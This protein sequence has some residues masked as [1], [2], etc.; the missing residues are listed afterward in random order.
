MKI[1][2]KYILKCIHEIIE[3]YHENGAKSNKN[4]TNIYLTK[5]SMITPKFLK[6]KMLKPMYRLYLKHNTKTN[7]LE[8]KYSEIDLKWSLNFLEYSLTHEV[9]FN[10]DLFENDN[11]KKEIIKFIKNKLYMALRGQL[12]T[13]NLFTEDD[14]TYFKKYD[15]FFR[16]N[17][18]FKN[19]N[20]TDI[21]YNNKKYTLASSN[22][23]ISS[24]YHNYGLDIIP[25]KVISNIA[26]KNILDCGAFVGDSALIFEKLKPKKIYSFEP[27][28]K[29][30]LKLIE[31]IKLNNLNPLITPIKKGLG[32]KNK[33]VYLENALDSSYIKKNNLKTKDSEKI[34]ITTIDN[35]IQDNV[36]LI[37]MDI[38]GYELEAIKGAEKTIK[39]NRP[40]LLICLYHTGKDFFEIPKLINKWNL[41]YTYRFLNLYKIHPTNERVLIAYPN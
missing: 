15:D 40:V 8:Y 27:D 3:E 19:A 21:N 9:N 33:N 6:E 16:K 32:D 22:V 36:G 41:N 10:L 4:K 29:N 31:T 30:Y 23:G 25:K 18:K 17:I 24:F 37:K 7:P 1:N 34:E 28:T 20:Y 12:F 5:I 14:L 11:D 35:F 13:Y 39:K 26:H 38:E 2:N